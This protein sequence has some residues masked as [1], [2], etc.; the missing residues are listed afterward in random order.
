MASR[1]KDL[2][3]QSATIENIDNEDIQ[4]SL[5]LGEE[6]TVAWSKSDNFL[7][8]AGSSLLIDQFHYEV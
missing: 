8:N 4:I 1:M 5:A 7:I 6:K 3:T 2:D